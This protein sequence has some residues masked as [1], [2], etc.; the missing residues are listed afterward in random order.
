[1]CETACLSLN[2]PKLDGK[3]RHALAE[4]VICREELYFFDQQSNNWIKRRLK[5]ELDAGI[6]EQFISGENSDKAGIVM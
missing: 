1:M 3:E 4:E 2:S 5:Q 6:N